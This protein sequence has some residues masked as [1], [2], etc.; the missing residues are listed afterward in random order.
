LLEGQALSTASVEHAAALAGQQLSP[1]GD[2]RG[3]AEYR[4]EMAI[5]LTRRALMELAA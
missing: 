2:F 5:V 1:T 4:K 3:S